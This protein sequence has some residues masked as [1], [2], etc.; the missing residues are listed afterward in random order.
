MAE[1]GCETSDDIFL[2]REDANY[3]LFQNFQL[4]ESQGLPT[5]EGLDSQ[6][7]K[8]FKNLYKVRVRPG[9]LGIYGRQVPT[10]TVTLPFARCYK[11]L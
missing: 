3:L 11:F 9:Y 1:I 2:K 7:L 10:R 8:F 5:L 4:L 6:D